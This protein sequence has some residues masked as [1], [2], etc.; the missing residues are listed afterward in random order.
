MTVQVFEDG[1]AC[2]GKPANN[3]SNS[4]DDSPEIATLAINTR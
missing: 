1:A 3:I 4:S 2:P